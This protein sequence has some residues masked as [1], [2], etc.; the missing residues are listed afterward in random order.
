MKQYQKLLGLGL[1]LG[2]IATL[3]LW[4]TRGAEAPSTIA[5]ATPVPQVNVIQPSL[6]STTEWDH[7]S[8]RFE[9][10]D[11]VEVRARVSGHLVGIHFTDGEMVEAGEVLFTIDPRPFEAQVAIAKANLASAQAEL[12]RA[13]SELER[14]KRTVASNAISRSLFDTMV[15]EQASA[16]VAVQAA[17]AQLK[18]AELDL[19]F[20]QIRAPVSGRVDRHHIDVGNLVE[21]NDSRLTSIVSMDPIYVT[22]DVNQNAYLRY[23]RGHMD[24]TRISSREAANPV[25]IA[26]GDE[27]EFS[28]EGRME[29]VANQVHRGTGTIRAR[30]VV[31][32]PDHFLT[33]GLFARVQLLAREEAPTVLVPDEVISTRQSERIV[34]VMDSNNTVQTRRVELGPLVDG[35]RVVR[36][37]LVPED[38]VIAG[39]VGRL[40]VG[41]TVAAL[42]TATP[43]SLQ[44]AA[45]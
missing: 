24:G 8:G 37:G 11:H 15:A 45:R 36:S 42:P 19:E 12:A 6:R 17:Q 35:Q 34:F 39:N 32:N 4:A 41:Q 3:G 1:G 9:A 27:A 13:E 38:R 40:R 2:L 26:L 22:F 14:G 18:L 20:T 28:F 5:V 21:A 25:R 33:P 44:L 7:Y 43:S 31:D 30:A 23:A 16:V 29:Y 10:V